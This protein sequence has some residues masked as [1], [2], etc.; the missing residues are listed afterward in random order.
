MWIVWFLV[1]LVALI[2]LL[3][4]RFWMKYW[5]FRRGFP[6]PTYRQPTGRPD[7]RS[8]P[9]H[10]VTVTWVGHSTMYIKMYGIRILTDP[11]F[12]ER[13]GIRLGPT[14]VGPRRYTAPALSIEDVIGQVDVILLSH[15]HLDHFDLPTLRALANPEITVVTAAQTGHLVRRAGFTRVQELNWDE[16]VTLPTG[17]QVKALPVRH[18]GRRFPWNT[19][20]GWN[21][22]LV[23]YQGV[24]LLF[25]G[26]TA[27]TDTFSVLKERGHDIDLVFMPIGAY[28]PSQFQSSHCTPEQAWEMFL[29][30]GG[31]RFVPM[32]WGTFVLSE[33]PVDE[34]IRRLLDVAGQDA[35][36]VVIQSHGDVYP[37]P[38]VE[39]PN[40]LDRAQWL[41][42]HRPPTVPPLDPSAS[43]HPV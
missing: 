37:L 28:S 4:G 34:P 15:A 33:E 30:T 38:V 43:R 5:K 1:A 27:Y 8:W 17:M 16:S 18:W 25:A 42:R 2:G 40:Y 31:K 24:E 32:H 11:V 9:N 21:G 39:G 10:E 7:P 6:H 14:T 29:H 22:Y 26:D 35:D 13:V 41:V 20:Y 23:D 3:I 12:S 36:R 19:K